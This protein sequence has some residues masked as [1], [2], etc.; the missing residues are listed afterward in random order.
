[1][2][3]ALTRDG[4]RPT[5]WSGRTE[6]STGTCVSV[7]SSAYRQR[8]ANTQRS[9]GRGLTGTRPGISSSRSR[10]SPGRGIA[11]I[12][13]T[14]YGCCGAAN[15]SSTAASSTLRPAYMT[16]TRSAMSATTPRLCVTSTIA[17]PNSSR[18]SRIRSRMPAWIVTSSA[19]VGSSAI[20][21][22]GSHASAIAITTRWR[23]PPESWCGYSSTRRA[24]A[25]MCTSWSSSTARLRAARRETPRCRR[26]ASP[27]WSPTVKTGLREL[28]GSWKTYAISRP[29]T[30]R[31]RRAPN[32]SRSWPSNTTLPLTL[33]VS[34]SSRTSDMQV[35]LFP[36][37]D[38]PTMPRTSRGASENDTRSTAWIGPSS[39]SKRTE[40][41][42]TSRRGSA[43]N[44][45]SWGRGRRATRPRGR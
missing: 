14:V 1:M 6:R 35:T 7:I 25:G 16:M 28:I 44:A 10:R 21:I 13:P 37:P 23:I 22:F 2:R 11:P 18:T 31:S 17:V 12:S 30:R 27:I 3:R 41:S 19:V 45:P 20:S 39:V 4:S 26:T 32:A 36:H 29:R 33:A 38:S 40:R 8:S 34:G 43:L 15:S 9:S 42:F 24:A 5:R